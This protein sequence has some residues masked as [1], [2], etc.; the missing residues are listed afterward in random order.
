M[1]RD[2][3]THRRGSF[4]GDKLSMQLR[5]DD[6]RKKR[7]YPDSPGRN[8]DDFPRKSNSF[9]GQSGD[10]QHTQTSR[11]RSQDE[12]A[13]PPR[14]S[15]DER[16][17]NGDRP[18]DYHNRDHHEGSGNGNEYRGERVHSRERTSS[19]DVRDRE[20]N[21]LKGEILA[22]KNQCL[23][24]RLECEKTKAKMME[25]EAKLAEQS[26]LLYK[27][28]KQHETDRSRF[29]D[30]LSA[31]RRDLD[32]ERIEREKAYSQLDK[33][34]SELLKNGEQHDPRFPTAQ[35]QSTTGRNS[36]GSA[37]PSN[38]PLPRNRINS[39][40]EADSRNNGHDNRYRRQSQ[41]AQRH[42]GPDHNARSNGGVGRKYPDRG[43]PQK[44]KSPEVE[45]RKEVEEVNPNASAIIPVDEELL[46]QMEE[47]KKLEAKMKIEV[48]PE[49]LAEV[50]K[51]IDI[52]EDYPVDTSDKMPTLEP[53]PE[54]KK[55][56]NKWGSQP[57]HTAH[58]PRMP[59][60]QSMPMPMMMP[61]SHGFPH[62][63]GGMGFDHMPIHMRFQPMPPRME[64]A[65]EMMARQSSMHPFHPPP[66]P[67][68][69][70]MRQ[71]SLHSE[72][73]REP[74]NHEIAKEVILAKAVAGLYSAD[75]SAP[76]EPVCECERGTIAIKGF[77]GKP[78]SVRMV[79][80]DDASD[81]K[82]LNL[83]V[84]GFLDMRLEGK[85]VCFR[86]SDPPE[87]IPIDYIIKLESP[88]LTY[89]FWNA[90]MRS[91]ASPEAIHAAVDDFLRSYSNENM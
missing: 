80:Y 38:G 75:P 5:E 74:V 9:R 54:R 14:D 13:F 53:V 12:Q 6:L 30:D 26:D 37:Q 33:I 86:I 23:S 52:V 64:N 78:D 62:P 29:Q 28:Q 49:A 22:A 56:E 41:P 89:K 3:D 55:S 31:L 91:R 87:H 32:R 85:E 63:M 88:D 70:F 25:K 42:L 35:K 2:R 4:E 21:T 39:W 36:N 81:K 83:L 16:R 20:W 65:Q 82:V 46:K 40:N 48:P 76:G 27:I 79:M 7:K 67:N 11:S 73:G 44:T 69:G 71:S 72:M 58:L 77:P 47:Q 90:L 19:G 17:S 43:P 8:G 66:H 59:S 50:T 57:K 15:R 45:R 51:H 84:S 60:T 34:V 18:R 1:D 24:A 68:G 10:Q 61:T